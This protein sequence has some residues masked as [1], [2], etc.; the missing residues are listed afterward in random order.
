MESQTQSDFQHD[1]LNYDS[2]PAGRSYRVAQRN[3][4]MNNHWNIV[5]ESGAVHSPYHT[6]YV[7]PESGA[8]HSPYHTQYVVP[9]SGTVHSPYHT[10]YGYPYQSQY[11]YPYHSPYGDLLPHANGQW[12]DFTSFLNPA[13]DPAA[14]VNDMT[15]SSSAEP[16]ADWPQEFERSDAYINHLE[17]PLKNPMD[18][19]SLSEEAQAIH[20]HAIRA[21][22]RLGGSI[23][24]STCSLCASHPPCSPSRRPSRHPSRRPSRHRIACPF[25][26]LNSSSERRP[27]RNISSLHRHKHRPSEVV[28]THRCLLLAKKKRPLTKSESDLLKLN[29][30]RCKP[31]RDQIRNWW[32]RDQHPRYPTANYEDWDEYWDRVSR[33][34]ERMT[35][36]RNL[37]KTLRDKCFSIEKLLPLSTWWSDATLYQVL[38][39]VD[40]SF[41]V[42]NLG[43]NAINGVLNNS[44][45]RS[46]AEVTSLIL[47][48]DSMRSVASD[49]SPQFCST[50]ELVSLNLN[51]ICRNETDNKF[52]GSIP[53]SSVGCL[54]L[55]LKTFRYFEN[56]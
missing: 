28:I 35:L 30:H 31:Y 5:P 51:F 2:I 1:V 10:Q 13:V 46:T 53:I 19:E 33:R 26:C 12:G 49:T 8:V 23:G 55:T 18:Q 44:S 11:G 56:S 45:P 6:Q 9:E 25:W 14:T 36:R 17:D 40:K 32:E 21:N 7:V 20:N 3:T 41:R 34:L 50:K 16:F 54:S 48:A 24:M 4:S 47:M 15:R 37:R 42:W 43:L 22:I 29:S 39:L 52:P 27:Y 38:K